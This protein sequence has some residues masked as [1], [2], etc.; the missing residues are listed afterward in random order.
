MECL[1]ESQKMQ[2]T[3][4]DLYKYSVLETISFLNG[5]V[6]GTYNGWTVEEVAERC[7]WFRWRLNPDG[8]WYSSKG[9]TNRHATTGSDFEVDQLI[10]VLGLR[11]LSR[12]EDLI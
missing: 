6:N 2:Y 7:S 3:K 1:V 8:G 9:S 11:V 10:L 5:V 4:N 12:T